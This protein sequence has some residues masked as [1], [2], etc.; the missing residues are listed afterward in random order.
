MRVSPLLLAAALAI[1]GRAHAFCGF[2]VGGA[3]AKLYNNATEVVLMRQGTTTV[4]SMENNYQGPPSQFAMVV[5]V[6]AVI[7]REQVQ[8]L[9]RELF[10]KID[11]LGA[12]RLVEY[13]EQ[14]PCAP[15]MVEEEGQALGAVDD[16]DEDAAPEKASHAYHVK[17]VAQFSVGEYD[18]EVLSATES[19]GL[20]HWLRDHHYTI[21]DGA[22]P[23]LRPYVEQG[24]KWFVAKVDPKKVKFDP[25][26]KM[27][28][29]SPLRFSYDSPE[30]TLPIRLGLANSSGT[31]DLIVNILAPG[32]TRYEA[33]NYPNVL[34]PT[35]LQVTDQVRTRFGEFYAALFD[36]A[37]AA[38][39]H[40]VVT[41]YAWATSSC[42]PCPGP[43]LDGGDLAT[44]GADVLG[45]RY[46]DVN[47]FTLTRL[48]ARYGKDLGQDLVFRAVDKIE[49]GR[50]VP[51]AHGEIAMQ[52]TQHAGTNNFQGRY[53]ILHPWQGAMDC[54]SPRRGN[55]GEAPAGGQQQQIATATNTAFAP[56]GGVQLASLIA[57]DAPQIG[58]MTSTP[59]TPPPPV[60]RP[61]ACGG[62]ET[63]GPT[64]GGSFALIGVVGLALRRRRR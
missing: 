42:D 14:D 56:R 47:D 1:P 52:P 63:R 9:S 27:A 7:K 21:P 15:E 51:D 20:D 39:P 53:M 35:N 55:W 33:A 19:T 16:R 25:K 57:K 58:L 3:G 4:L 6:P 54:P 26:T 8:T 48:H 29:L 22:E 5:P 2:Y 49:G 37:I 59:I 24:M 32:D 45:A 41:E 10:D 44:F 64:G 23:L 36:H 38:Q 12:P 60:P 61:Q 31:Q 34:I 11:T 28:T 43:T 18:I 13:W 17:V 30:F 50:G 62:C 46:Q 40:A